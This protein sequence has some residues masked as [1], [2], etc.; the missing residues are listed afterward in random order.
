MNESETIG[1][2]VC[3]AVIAEYTSPTRNVLLVGNRCDE[4][5]LTDSQLSNIL[6]EFQ[7]QHFMVSATENIDVDEPFFV[8][9]DAARTRIIDYEMIHQYSNSY[10]P[11]LPYS[12]TLPSFPYNSSPSVAVA[13]SSPSYFFPCTPYSSCSV[14]PVD[15][16]FE[17]STEI[18]LRLP[19][20]LIEAQE[21]DYYYLMPRDQRLFDIL[22]SNSWDQ[23]YYENIAL[24]RVKDS[25]IAHT[26]SK[27][28]E[29]IVHET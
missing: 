7:L 2:N 6:S 29:E 15:S 25:K 23:Q 22:A 12:F 1:L 9:A 17:L 20:T 13:S 26:A 16:D 28:M 3:R 19:P 5:N 8:L 10:D 11:S 27:E 24:E 18:L 4:S 14:L 21:M